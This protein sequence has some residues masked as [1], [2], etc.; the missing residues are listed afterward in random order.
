M[1][2]QV[3]LCVIIFERVQIALSEQLDNPLGSIVRNIVIVNL[4]RSRRFCITHILA[5]S[6]LMLLINFQPFSTFGSAKDRLQVNLGAAPAS[7]DS[8]LPIE[9]CRKSR[10]RHWRNFPTSVRL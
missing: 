7:K 9:L 2:A 8:G 6:I 3:N 10:D 4:L 5:F 1:T